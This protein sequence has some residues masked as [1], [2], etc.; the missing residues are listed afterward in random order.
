[1][2][3]DA[4]PALAG[5]LLLALALPAAALDLDGAKAQGLIGEMTTGYVGAVSPSAPP[6]VKQLVDQVNAKRRA[7]YEDIARKN[8]TA[9][10]AVAALAGTKLIERAPP[11]GWIGE[12]GH[13]YQKK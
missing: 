3:S 11:G 13:W 7:S 1:M 4:L 9:V 6:E 12:G 8:G 5:A 10:E 2:K